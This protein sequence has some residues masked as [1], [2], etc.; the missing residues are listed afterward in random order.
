MK[1]RIG[2]V[3]LLALGWVAAV[4][5]P[6]ADDDFRRV[7]SKS[8]D[9]QRGQQLFATCAGCHGADGAGSAERWVP[10]IGRQRYPVVVRQLVD[11]RHGRRWDVRMQANAAEHHLTDLQSI[12]DVAAFVADLV[13]PSPIPRDPG[14]YA[15]RGR[16]LYDGQCARCHGTHGEGK[17]DVP[18]LASQTYSYLVR[19]VHDIVEGRRPNMPAAHVRLLEKLEMQDIE[20][21]ADTMS[22][23]E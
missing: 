12:A 9:L 5:S 20:G 17:A 7:M 21:L 4:A 23:E 22:Q 14:P 13:P 3:V 15:A 2:I 19:Q 6:L 11:Y 18:R 16:E 1:L 8:P 10:R